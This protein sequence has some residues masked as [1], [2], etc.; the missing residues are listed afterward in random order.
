MKKAAII[1]GILFIAISVT[2]MT[3]NFYTIHQYIVPEDIRI[4][5]QINNS[6]YF[7]EYITQFFEHTW[8]NILFAMLFFGL[9]IL[10][11]IGGKKNGN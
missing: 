10:E 1:K 5:V 6:A 9:G 8:Q 2:F 11:F 4:Q 7:F 3:V